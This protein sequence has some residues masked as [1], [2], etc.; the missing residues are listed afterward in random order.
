MGGRA[1]SHREAASDPPRVEL[2]LRV[3]HVLGDV[4]RV[5]P[6]GAV[7]YASGETGTVDDVGLLEVVQLLDD[8]AVPERDVELHPQV[9]LSEEG[10][11]RISG[12][13][14]QETRQACVREAVKFPLL[15]VRRVDAGLYLDRVDVL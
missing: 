10:V 13:C 3:L 12:K 5:R 15:P 14:H 6:V 8:R 9:S 1:G 7:P 2:E 11:G 4:E